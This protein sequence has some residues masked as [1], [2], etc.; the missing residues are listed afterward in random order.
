MTLSQTH[1]SIPQ[2]SVYLYSIT[3]Q[4][5]EYKIDF[6]DEQVVSS[7]ID[8]FGVFFETRSFKTP[9]KV[10]RIEFNQLGY[11]QLH[12]MDYSMIE[13][14]LW[15]ESKIPNLDELDITV[16]YDTYLSFDGTEVPMTIIQKKQSDDY[17]KPCLVYAYGGFGECLLPR[18]DLF[19]LLFVELFNGV[20]GLYTGSIDWQIWWV[21]LHSV[22]F[23]KHLNHRLIWIFVLFSFFPFLFLHSLSFHPYSRWWWAWWSMVTKTNWSWAKFLRFNI[24]SGVFKRGIVCRHCWFE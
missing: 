9:R 20:V 8:K 14:V 17:R 12:E 7:K 3:H 15:K 19:F 11:R 4:R 10:Y 16:K 2:S 18:F 24:R 13:P 5:I 22:S 21:F 23:F 6:K 1:F